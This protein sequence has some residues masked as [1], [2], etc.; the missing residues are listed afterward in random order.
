MGLLPQLHFDDELAKLLKKTGMK[1]ISQKNVI[2]A[3][4]IT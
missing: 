4:K 3:Q 2:F 1:R